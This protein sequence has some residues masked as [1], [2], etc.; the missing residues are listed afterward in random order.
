[1]FIAGLAHITLPGSE[2]EAWIRGGEHGLIVAADTAAVSRLGH[3][4][5][6]PSKRETVAVQIPTEGGLVPKHRVLHE[7]A[8]R[9]KEMRF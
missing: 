3:I 2:D 4:T 9:G 6:Y 7:G 1:M 8:C 5:D